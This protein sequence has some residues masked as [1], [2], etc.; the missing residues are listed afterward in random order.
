MYNKNMYKKI[1]FSFILFSYLNAS[2]VV[3]GASQKGAISSKEFYNLITN[4]TENIFNKKSKNLKIILKNYESNELLLSEYKN[5]KILTL[6]STPK[7]YF[8]HE[9]EFNKYTKYQ[10]KVG[11]N[12]QISE[13]YYLIA[14]KDFKDPFKN[15]HK[16]KISTLN[17]F[18]NE[19]D[20]FRYFIYKKYK[21]SF[22]NIVRGYTTQKKESRLIYDIF[23]DKNKMSIVNSKTYETLTELN[24]QLKQK[25]VILAKSK[26][27]F[28][29]AMG[30][31]HKNMNKKEK[32]E[33]FQLIGEIESTLKTSPFADNLKVSDFVLVTKEN[34][35][36]LKEFYNEYEFL[37]KKY[38]NKVI[39]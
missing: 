11:F 7:F 39:N 13:Q 18:K 27:I 17:G 16:A 25:I 31:A 33:L 23:F 8:A 1:L 26:K 12:N 15:L 28:I 14:N 32:Q 22:N 10:W 38:E 21:T 24:L 37:Y 3:I 34:T 9:E 20:W 30:F 5:E 19:D 29:T 6:L 35:K 2:Q 36:E 4:V